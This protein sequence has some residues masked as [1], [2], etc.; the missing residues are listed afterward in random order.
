MLQN[1]QFFQLICSLIVSNLIAFFSMLKRVWEEDKQN[2]Y[3][4][5]ELW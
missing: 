5:T 3:F 2:K 1:D 4:K